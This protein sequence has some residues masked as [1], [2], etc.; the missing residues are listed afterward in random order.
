MIFHI[1]EKLC[2]YT[3]IINLGKEVTFIIFSNIVHASNGHFEKLADYFV[4]SEAKKKLNL[5]FLTL[6]ISWM[7]KFIM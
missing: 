3:P 7:L 6:A 2:T 1:K 4:Q 5:E